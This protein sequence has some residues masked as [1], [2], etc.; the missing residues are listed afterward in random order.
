MRLLDGEGGIPPAPLVGALR[1]DY[2]VIAWDARDAE[3]T[4]AVDAAIE[5]RDKRPIDELG[6]KDKLAWCG[7]HPA[8]V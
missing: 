2:V 3:V 1:A 7:M 6:R 4:A 5:A 8:A